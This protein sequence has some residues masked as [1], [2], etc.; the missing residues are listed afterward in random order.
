MTTNPLRA[1]RSDGF[2]EM[3][4]PRANKKH[5]SPPGAS[6]LHELLLRQ[7]KEQGRTQQPEPV[8][9]P[10]GILWPGEKSSFLF[11]NTRPPALSGGSFSVATLGLTFSLQIVFG[12]GAT[13]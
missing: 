3:Q 2:S 10:E 1:L 13:E 7:K 4:P 9:N 8:P 12:E 11:R 5:L 6:D